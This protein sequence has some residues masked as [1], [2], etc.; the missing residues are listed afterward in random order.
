MSVITES[1]MSEK[2]D[3]IHFQ[4]AKDTLKAMIEILDVYV[5]N[6]SW[7]HGEPTREDCWKWYEEEIFNESRLYKALGKDEARTVLNIFQRFK[8]LCQLTRKYKNWAI[9]EG[10]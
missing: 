3:E 8:E 5:E 7:V 1:E 2:T 9:G 10:K 4:L 6:R